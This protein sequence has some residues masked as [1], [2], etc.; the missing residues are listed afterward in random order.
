MSQNYDRFFFFPSPFVFHY[1]V[2][3][4]L[5]IKQNLQ[6]TLKSLYQSHH[7]ENKY[8]WSKN[9]KYQSNMCTNFNVAKQQRSWYTKSD[10]QAFVWN[11]IDQ[12][13]SELNQQTSQ[14]KLDDIW[15]NVYQKGD[16]APLHNHGNYGI[17]GVYL[18]QLN[19][20]NKT[21]FSCN[22]RTT[23]KNEHDLQYYD[24]KHVKEGTVLLFPSQLNHSVDP[25]E[26][27]RMTISFN[28][29]IR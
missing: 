17:S 29:E 11:P 14:C 4:H 1:E 2:P 18:L 13:L 19:E 6:S 25:A 16:Y 10:L 23:I 12:L 26:S 20:P 3:E 22:T 24:T 5:T 21:V 27:T 7:H 15:W 8:K 9:S 28:V